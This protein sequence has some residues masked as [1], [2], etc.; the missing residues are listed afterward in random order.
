M[1]TKIPSSSLPSRLPWGT[2]AHST[3]CAATTMSPTNG[4]ASVLGRTPGLVGAVVRLT[5]GL[6]GA[7]V[8]RLTSGLVTGAD[9]ATAAPPTGLSASPVAAAGAA[10]TLASG[11]SAAG[12]SA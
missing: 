5:P 6:V 4:R 11:V 8:V 9:G 7:P 12:L 2:Y 10:A 3:F 1:Y